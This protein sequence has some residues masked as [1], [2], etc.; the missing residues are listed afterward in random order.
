MPG[1]RYSPIEA[2]RERSGS[3]AYGCRSALCTV[4]PVGLGAQQ[5]QPLLD[6]SQVRLADFMKFIAAGEIVLCKRIILKVVKFT[7]FRDEILRAHNASMGGGAD[8]HVKRFGSNIAPSEPRIFT[9]HKRLGLVAPRLNGKALKYIGWREAGDVH[10]CGREIEMAGECIDGFW[11]DARTV[12]Y[13]RDVQMFV[14]KEPRK[15]AAESAMGCA[16]LGAM[17]AGNDDDSIFSYAV[18]PKDAAQ[19][20]Q[21]LVHQSEAHI[22]EN[23][24][25]FLRAVLR[26]AAIGANSVAYA[27]WRGLRQQFGDLQLSFMQIEI[28]QESEKGP[29]RAAR[30]KAV[31]LFVDLAGIE[32]TSIGKQVDALVE[33]REQ[34][35]APFNS[36][37]GAVAEPVLAEGELIIGLKLGDFFEAGPGV[38]VEQSALGPDGRQQRLA[39]A[40]TARRARSFECADK[41]FRIVKHASKFRHEDGHQ[42]GFA[43]VPGLPRSNEFTES[44]D[45]DRAEPLIEIDQVEKI[46]ESPIIAEMGRA[47]VAGHQ[48]ICL[49]TILLKKLRERNRTMSD[50]VVIAAEVKRQGRGKD[51]W[52]GEARDAAIGVIIGTVDP[53]RCQRIEIGRNRRPIARYA[54]AVITQGIDDEQNYIW[55]VVRGSMSELPIKTSLE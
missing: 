24:T 40:A 31:K 30:Q 43:D 39:G 27:P 35:F 52:K 5:V 38:A 54:H 7:Q 23:A 15:I 29:L 28:M 21:L 47:G 17:I 9:P 41:I 45:I 12:Q 26:N 1:S 22:V 48:A 3:G 51:T 16:G 4:L 13:E 44:S 14:I 20:P 25:L 11:R 19:F 33:T 34:D 10:D 6:S 50:A 49:E 37:P 36:P 42:F 8:A 53:T 2:A 18:A 32:S 55:H 46:I